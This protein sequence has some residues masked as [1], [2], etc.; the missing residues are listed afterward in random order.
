MRPPG[1]SRR[2]T[3][4]PRSSRWKAVPMDRIRKYAQVLGPFLGLVLVIA[5]FGALEPER[6]LS[7]YNLKTVANQSVIVALGAIGMALV[8]I[9]G[10]I[11]LSVG[12]NIAFGTVAVAWTLRT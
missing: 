6:F 4:V 5:L 3:E 10:G 11:D 7:F 1:A 12:S 9:A 2:G 8:M